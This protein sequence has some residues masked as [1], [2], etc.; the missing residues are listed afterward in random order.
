MSDF[1]PLCICSSYIPKWYIASIDSIDLS[2]SSTALRIPSG[3]EVMCLSTIGNSQNPFSLQ[4]F[5][6][7]VWELQEQPEEEK[8][9]KTTEEKL[10]TLIIW[11]SIITII[12]I[13]L[14]ITQK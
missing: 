1:L 9:P 3:H 4:F 2:I 12:C 14:S 5:N 6:D 8:P 11:L 7:E 13:I 10:K